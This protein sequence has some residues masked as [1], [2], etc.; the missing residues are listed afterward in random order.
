M[1]DYVGRETAFFRVLKCPSGKQMRFDIKPCLLLNLKHDL[2]APA[3]IP[4][5]YAI[6]EK[7]DINIAPLM[8]ISLHTRTK[9]I[10]RANGRHPP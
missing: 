6:Q 7:R 3:Q 4:I 1:G 2:R 10:N 8:R 9:H 5:I